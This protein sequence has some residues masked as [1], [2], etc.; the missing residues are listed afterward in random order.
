MGVYNG[1]MESENT[2]RLTAEQ[3]K[4]K[5][6]TKVV[7]ENDSLKRDIKRLEKENGWLKEAEYEHMQGKVDLQELVKDLYNR[8]Y[9]LNGGDIHSMIY[10]QYSTGVEK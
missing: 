2:S 10:R 3:I 8:I 4:H 9:V 1:C 5:Q 6:F 7:I